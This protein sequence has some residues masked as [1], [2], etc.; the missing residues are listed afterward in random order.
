M[1]V[2]LK[3]NRSFLVFL[4]VFGLFRTALADWNPIP[5]ESM[6]PTLLDGDVVLVN[7]I[8]RL[9]KDGHAQP[10]EILALTY[11]KNSATELGERVRSLVGSANV[12]TATFHDYCLDLLKRS[13]KDFGVLDEADL[14]IYLRR[15]LR[16]LHLEYFVRAANVGEFLRDL[17]TFQIGRAHV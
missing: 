10:E 3:N 13:Q 16:E 7:R 12:H 9:V 17:L 11:T 2:W 4:M 15:R 14:W 5:S 8:A 1:K 6:H